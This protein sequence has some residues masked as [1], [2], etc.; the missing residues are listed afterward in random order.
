MRQHPR[1]TFRKVLLEARG[2][3]FF[4]ML[5]VAIHFFSLLNL[6]HLSFWHVNVYIFENNFSSFEMIKVNISVMNFVI[7]EFRF[8]ALKFVFSTD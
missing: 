4:V 2:G 8:Y 7:V 5:W 6:I 1:Q 3:E